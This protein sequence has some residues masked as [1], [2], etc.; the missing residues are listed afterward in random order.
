MEKIVE[1][2]TIFQE[3]TS[4]VIGDMDLSHLRLVHGDSYGTSGSGISA[5]PEVVK[6][7]TMALVGWQNNCQKLDVNPKEMLLQGIDLLKAGYADFHSFKH[8]FGRYDA[9]WTFHLGGFLNQMKSLAKKA[10]FMWEPWAAE[11][12][13]FIGKRSRVKFMNLG[14]RVDCH[15]F[16]FLG[17]D[18]LDVLC[19][20][21][22]D[23]KDPDPIG[24]F[25]TRHN[26]AFDPT[27]EFNLEEFKAAV[28][29]ALNNEKLVKSGIQAEFALVQD[30]TLV[31]VKF[32]KSL[33]QK[34]KAVSDSGG[35]VNTCLRTLS[36]N[37]GQDS[38]ET[39]E[40]KRLQ[41]FNNLSNRLIKTI[42]YII[43]DDDQLDRV[44]VTTLT[45][46]MK[47]LHKLWKVTAPEEQQVE[48]A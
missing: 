13:S 22:A 19:S 31:G 5:A 9:E 25:L 32:E 11:K 48:A 46:L 41:D 27:R 26:I 4:P 39:D 21:T 36:I 24:D 43:K 17:V 34:L 18:R 40:D 33:V 37:K 15:R 16:S 8:L 47:K 35:D 1:N 10:G 38:T 3:Q 23:S 42:D 2:T 14:R 12:L 7:N 44:D 45:V 29:A 6:S 28:D 30:L 20:A